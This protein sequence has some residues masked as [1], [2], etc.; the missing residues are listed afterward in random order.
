MNWEHLIETAKLLAGSDEASP[1]PGRPRQAVLRRAV[2]TAYYAMFHA[3][4]LSNAETLVGASPTGHNASLWVDTYRTLDHRVAKNRLGQRSQLPQEIAVRNF[5]RVFGSLQ[6]QR[7]RA[8]YDPQ[9]RFA[10]SEVLNLIA[11]AEAA[12]GAFCAT[13]AQTRRS[14]A[15]YLLVRTRS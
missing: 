3:L 8:D 13:S 5:A 15:V 4:C 9:A 10:R 7:I 2:S 6:E 11:R 14:L 12:T 1:A